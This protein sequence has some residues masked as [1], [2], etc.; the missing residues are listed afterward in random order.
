VTAVVV[1]GA[2]VAARLWGDWHRA[3]PV[4]RDMEAI[5]FAF[6][7]ILAG[8][9]ILLVFTREEVVVADGVLERR[10]VLGIPS[11]HSLDAVGGM[12]R[13]DVT[14]LLGPPS[15]YVIVYDK[16]HRCLFKMN[17]VIWDPGDVSRLHAR[18]GGD[19]RTRPATMSEVEAE[20]P[21]SIPWLITHPWLLIAMEFVVLLAALF[22]LV[23][24]QDA[25]A[26]RL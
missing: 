16:Q 20:F 14:Y 18:L 22:A 19:G 24:I 13:R 23:S 7:I 15:H 2:F 12:A 11:R 9:V 8:L 25:I 4:A 1:T 10:N 6:L 21:G 5:L 26:S 17:R 3:T